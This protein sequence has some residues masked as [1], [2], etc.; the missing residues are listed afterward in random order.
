MK[1]DFLDSKE[2]SSKADL[3]LC[4]HPD[5]KEAI[6]NLKD[7]LT[8]RILERDLQMRSEGF[9]GAHATHPCPFAEGL[10]M[11]EKY[12]TFEDFEKARGDE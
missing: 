8:S 4:A 3:V 9:E 10:L 12:K 11:V 7:W 6:D 5:G 1:I 2:F